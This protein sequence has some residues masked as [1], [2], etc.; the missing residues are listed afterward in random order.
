M[1]D[2]ETV[3]ATLDGHESVA[4]VVHA[5]ADL[6]AVGSALGLAAA[7]DAETRV[8]APDGVKTRARRLAD[9]LAVE[10]RGPDDADLAAADSVVVLDAPASDRIAPVDLAAATGDVV[11]LDHHE[12]GDL[13]E[14]ATTAWVETT[15]GATAALAARV[16][17]ADGRSLD[18]D[19]AVALAA[20]LFDDT[21]S[22]A[23]ATG[24]GFRLFG[25]LLDAAGE[26]AEGLPAILEREQS[27]GTRVAATKAVV[28]ASGYRA[29]G[30]LLLTT[31]VGSDQSA[32]ARTLRAAGADVALVFSEREPGT[33]VVG[34][35]DPEILHLPDD[36]FEPLLDRFGGDGG[37]HGEAGVAK[38]HAAAHD[39]VREATLAAVETALDGALSELA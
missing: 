14:A 4:L 11:L 25:E 1:T 10:L 5:H 39:E 8:V 9:E 19:A 23:S 34:R 24:E 36:V 16:A 20:G 33:W 29:D 37:G 32:A 12:R 7:L 22:L 35:A 38:L 2:P 3:R 21:D 13:A 18:P 15:A 27:F 6:D 17:T 30:T 28:R 31:T 26:R